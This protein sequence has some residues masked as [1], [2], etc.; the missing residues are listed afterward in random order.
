MSKSRLGLLHVRVYYTCANSS[1][2][3]LFFALA[4]SLESKPPASHP[5]FLGFLPLALFRLPNINHCFLFSRISP[6]S[7]P[8]RTPTFRLFLSHFPY[9][10]CPLLSRHSTPLPCPPL[11]K[12]FAHSPADDLF[13]DFLAVCFSSLRCVPKMTRITQSSLHP[14]PLVTVWYSRR[15]IRPGK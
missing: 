5:F 6:I 10:S 9:P 11:P 3:C 14:L 1:F 8:S 2:A 13:F 4:C 7:Y 15:S 12:G